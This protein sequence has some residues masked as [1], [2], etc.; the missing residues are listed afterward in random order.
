[1][2]EGNNLDRFDKHCGDTRCEK[3]Q[4]YQNLCFNILFIS[5]IFAKIEPTE[6]YIPNLD[7]FFL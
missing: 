1:M 4:Q 5:N 6:M 3:R 2:F 7:V